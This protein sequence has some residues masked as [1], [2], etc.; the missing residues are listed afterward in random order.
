MSHE[1]YL[2]YKKWCNHSI[3]HNPV[4]PPP[5][6][7]CGNYVLFT[8]AEYI[9]GILASE[10]SIFCKQ[11]NQT[12]M[13]LL[14]PLWNSIFSACGLPSA[15][16]RIYLIPNADQSMSRK[17]LSK[18]YGP[19]SVES[20]LIYEL[21]YYISASWWASHL[22]PIYAT[23]TFWSVPARITFFSIWRKWKTRNFK[24]RIHGL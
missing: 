22:L 4:T 8:C 16:S 5:L 24:Y 18:K 23:G 15:W 6:N 1:K 17:K 20:F 7:N 21:T 12:C 10:S 2:P 11:L 3:S 13:D 14:L 19:V 9:F